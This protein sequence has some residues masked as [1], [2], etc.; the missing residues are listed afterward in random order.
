MP[1]ESVVDLLKQLVSLPSVN[2]EHTSCVE[3]ANEFRVADFLA[4]YLHERGFEIEW[5]RLTPERGSVIASYGPKNPL[6]TLLIEAHTDTVGVA[7]MIIPP[8]TPSV[9][10]GRLYGRGA[11]DTKGPMAAA[12]V[13]MEQPVLDALADAGVR[14]IFVGAF[15]EEKGNLGA[16]R[17]VEQGITADTV[18]V[19]EPTDL[20]IVHAHKG[21]LWYTL[22][23]IGAAA[24]GSDPAKGVNS[25]FAMAE[26]IQQLREHLREDEK[27]HQHADLGVPTLNIGRIQGGIAMNIVA[28]RCQIEVDRRL[29]PGEDPERLLGRTRQYLEGLKQKGTIV[30]F[31]VQPVIAG[32]PY[33]ASPETDGIR[34]MKDS[35]VSCG[36]EP[37]LATAAWY[38]DAGAF[39]RICQDVFVFGPGS[40]R[41]A[42]T[43]DEFI[44]VD[45]LEQGVHVLRSFLKSYAD[46]PPV[47]KG[48]T[49][50]A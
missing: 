47:R 38:S 25:I 27:T 5:D 6:H 33:W 21:A 16:E 14:T 1:K 35:L 46:A 3:E 24:H 8:F 7:D 42:H 11:C 12:L 49:P 19:L 20:A 44:E 28:H 26:V 30:D 15:G 18:L 43:V 9:R 23:L 13:A 50:H 36:Y 2:P 29:V 37:A 17:L 39:S 4:S 32:T 48:G 31:T 45:M 40:I 34:R 22:E 41:Q 10:D